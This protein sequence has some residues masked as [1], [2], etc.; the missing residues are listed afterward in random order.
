[1]SRK[2]HIT[3]EVDGTCD[4]NGILNQRLSRSVKLNPNVSH[5][6]ALATLESVSFFPNADSSNNK[7]YYSVPT[8]SGSAGPVNTITLLTSALDVWMS[9]MTKTKK[10]VTIKE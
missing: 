1:L 2:E 10:A 8:A 7:F 3:L 9:E 5:K 4:A 6:I